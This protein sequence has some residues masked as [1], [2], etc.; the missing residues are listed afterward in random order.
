MVW[1]IPIDASFSVFECFFFFV[2]PVFI[3]SFDS[4]IHASTIVCLISWLN[5][6][7]EVN[8]SFAIP[9]RC[10]YWSIK[11]IE[12]FYPLIRSRSDTLAAAAAVAINAHFKCSDF[13]LAA[14]LRRFFLF[15]FSRCWF[16]MHA[17][18]LI[19]QV[20]TPWPFHTDQMVFVATAVAR[21]FPLWLFSGRVLFTQLYHIEAHI[22]SPSRFIA[23]QRLL[24]HSIASTVVRRCCSR[25]PNARAHSSRLR[26]DRFVCYGLRFGCFVGCRSWNRSSVSYGIS[27]HVNVCCVSAH[28]SH[29]T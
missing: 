21:L 7:T 19:T 18:L 26:S 11:T 22:L 1:T 3:H 23:M 13:D 24:S 20:R 27:K 2:F 25:Q 16:D 15:H 4:F 12:T 29:S 17:A 9:L 28:L 10:S 6:H 5:Q 14:T 8:P